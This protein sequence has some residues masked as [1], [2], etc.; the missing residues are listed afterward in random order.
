VTARRLTT[1]FSAIAYPSI[2]WGHGLEI[3]L[4]SMAVLGTL[5]G[6]FGLVAGGISAW[7]NWRPIRSLVA[8]RGL[9]VLIATVPGLFGEEVN[10]TLILGGL[11]LAAV[12]AMIPLGVGYA[13]GRK[14]VRLRVRRPLEPTQ[15][16]SA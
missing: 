1:A 16:D 12:V 7:R 15:G 3:A 6:L 5:G 11:L 4:L 14:I 9:F 8:A 2:A 10:L 13:V